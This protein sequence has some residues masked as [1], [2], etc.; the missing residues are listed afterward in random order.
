MPVA[1]S[2]CM[3]PFRRQPTDSGFSL[4]EILMAMSVLM[5]VSAGLAA[6]TTTATRAT[7]AA[8]TETTAVLVA[9]S[10][11][12]QLRALAWG[13]GSAYAPA[14]RE[15]DDTDL[16]GPEPSSGGVGLRVAPASALDADMPG[17]VD[18]LDGSGRWIGTDGSAAQTARFVRRWSVRPISVGP[19]ALL[20]QVKVSDRLHVVGDVHVY[21]IKTRTAG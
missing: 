17:Y 4:L 1:L 5:I 21:T 15:D 20:L 3:T 10:R 9:V 7:M 12:E 8:R 18:Y 14:P 2:V 11:L 16:S 19:D 6:L 13:Y